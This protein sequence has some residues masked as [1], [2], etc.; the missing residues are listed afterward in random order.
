MTPAEL[1]RL[2]QAATPAPWAKD[3]PM[4]GQHDERFVGMLPHGDGYRYVMAAPDAAT[5]E[6]IAAARDALPALLDVVE[7]AQDVVDWAARQKGTPVLTKPLVGRL[8]AALSRLEGD[9]DG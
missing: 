6:L 1:R 5:A 7:A 4:L 9:H 3:A 8:R 2:E